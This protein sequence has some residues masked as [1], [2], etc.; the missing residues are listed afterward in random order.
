[1]AST[2]INLKV[3]ILSNIYVSV[4]LYN[5]A[6]E[7]ARFVSS[8]SEKLSHP[9]SA[10]AMGKH[11]HSGPD[12]PAS[13]Q[14]QTCTPNGEKCLLSYAW[15]P[16][17]K[18]TVTSVLTSSNCKKTLCWDVKESGVPFRGPH[19]KGTEYYPKPAKLLKLSSC[20]APIKCFQ[21]SSFERT[22][23]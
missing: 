2:G 15:K 1:M 11:A 6:G 17:A 18:L 8:W 13:M 23:S 16:A 4:G 9:A 20:S 10:S 5:I 3:E 7:N 12:R 22:P 19:S 21:A 14:F